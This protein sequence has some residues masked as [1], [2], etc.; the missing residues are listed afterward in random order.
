M[1]K[2]VVRSIDPG[3]LPEIGLIAFLLAF[4]L[5]VVRVF[6]MPRRDREAAKQIPLHDDDD[7]FVQTSHE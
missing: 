2:E 1:M 6:L 5:V 7:F 3:L 4:V